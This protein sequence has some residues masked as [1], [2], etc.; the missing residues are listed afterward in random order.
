MK[1]E[2]HQKLRQQPNLLS[3]N[4]DPH[5]F[6]EKLYPLLTTKNSQ[7]HLYKA[8]KYNRLHRFLNRFIHPN[9]I[10]TKS[11]FSPFIK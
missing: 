3:R 4:H 10:L 9:N 7:R 5:Q 2:Y 11:S 6:K 1:F 8:C